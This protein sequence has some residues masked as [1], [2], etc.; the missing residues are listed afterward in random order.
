[1]LEKYKKAMIRISEIFSEYSYCERKK[2]G[3]VISIDNGRVLIP[4]YNGTISGMNNCCEET[5]LSCPDCETGHKFDPNNITYLDNYVY[6]CGNCGMRH[7]Y[8]DLASLKK[9]LVTKTNE[10]TLHAE[11]NAIAYASKR[12]ISLEGS[13]I[14]ITASPCKTCSKLIAQAGIKEVV[15][16][17]H[18]RDLAGVDFL[19]KLGITTIQYEP[20]KEE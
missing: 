10:F 17:E 7:K 9:L 6:K 16:V 4:G 1:M 5:L 11:Q 2:V 8:T 13:T 12:G 19:K 18:Y 14:F 3:C 15:F 20:D